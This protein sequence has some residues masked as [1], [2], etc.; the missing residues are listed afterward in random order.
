VCM[1][2][3]ERV[4]VCVCVCVCVICKMEHEIT[5]KNFMLKGI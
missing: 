1:F 5:L 3:C 2:V 4:C